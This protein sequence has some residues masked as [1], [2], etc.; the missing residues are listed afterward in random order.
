[1]S[2]S[3]PQCRLGGR[4]GLSF[5]VLSYKKN[6]FNRH[7]TGFLISEYP[8]P[9]VAEQRY[10]RD[11]LLFLQVILFH[12]RGPK[13]AERKY[14]L[15]AFACIPHQRGLSKANEKKSTLCA[16]CVFAVKFKIIHLQRG[17]II[18]RASV[19]YT[20]PSL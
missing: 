12:R 11:K 17:Q 10:Y 13:G 8:Y 1:V 3:R 19:D 6:A 15:F 7:K 9:Y 14:F 16:L 18:G 4:F 2:S 5:I 20:S